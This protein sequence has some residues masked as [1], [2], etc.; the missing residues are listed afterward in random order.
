MPRKIILLLLIV[1]CCITL[2][3]NRVNSKDAS[4]AVNNE[5]KNILI[6]N[7]YHQGFTWTGEETQGI[8]NSLLESGN[9]ISI[10]VEYMDWKNHPSQENL[11]YLYDYYKYKYQTTKIDIIIATDDAALEFALNNRKDLFKDA[12]VVFCGINQAGIKTITEGADRVTGVTEVVDPTATIQLALQVNPD[13]KNVYLL[14][15]NTES[16]LSTGNLA[17]KQI[18]DIAPQ[19]NIISCNRLAF[20]D[21]LDTVHKLKRDSIVL[22]TTYYRDANNNIFEMDYVNRS[23]SEASTV[24]VYHLYDFGLNKGI[25]GGALLSGQLQGE[26]AADLALR[27]LS[28]EDPSDIP[29][30]TE[31]SYRVVFDYLQLTRF[32]IDP[33]VLPKD[34]RIINKP[35]SFFE[36]YQTLVIS[37]ISAFAVLIAFLLI[38][39]AYLRKIARMK[40]NLSESNEELTQLY[41]ELAASDEEMRQQYDEMLLI[42]EKIRLGEDKLTYLAYHDSLTGLLN[43]LSLYDRARHVFTPEN[44]KAALLFIDIDNFKN[45]NDAMG[46]AFG[47]QLIIKVSERLSS[48]SDDNR[49]LYRLSGDEFIMMLEKYHSMEEVENA[50][51]EIMAKFSDEFNVLESTLNISLSI[52]IA[53]YPEHGK[54]LEQL[55][56]YSDIA[57]YRAKEAGRKNYILY[58]NFMNEVFTERMS[59]EKHL[60]NALDN[61]EFEVYYQPQLDLKSNQITG[62]EALLRW[63]SPELGEV[64]PVKFIEVAED[65]R[66]ILP[67]GTWVIKNAC[68]FLKKLKDMGLEN[69]T[70][71]VNISILQ[72]LQPDFCDI[73]E[74]SLKECQLSPKSLELEITESI[75]ME[76]FE[77]IR[78]GLKRLHARDIRI[79]LDDFGKGYSS[80]NYLRQL[81]ITT[82]K[83]DKSFIDHICSKNTSNLTQH[84]ITIGKSMGM[85]VIAEGVEKQEQL[86]YLMEHDCDKIQGFLFS[87]PLPEN[88]I[89][90]LFKK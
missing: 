61:N 73:V 24:P 62:F 25:I 39:L 35:F 20:T 22:I 51:R 63:H 90:K 56:R 36:T 2:P 70:A 5:I 81:P 10:Q 85:C 15:D 37:V 12:P 31:G 17:I 16:G 88:E 32:H 19:L 77:S 82:L 76:S 83:V 23:I 21:L 44:G 41:E 34:A 54:D 84:I 28:G 8:I 78:P 9:N 71:S 3:Y 66:Y 64:S 33:D 27:I 67:I 68:R 89:I 14:Y 52:G 38:L 18:K 59:I 4:A 45:V 60:Q 86:E 58:D 74:S 1:L 6:I 13:L 48:I 55:L 46:H 75:L 72:L 80:L 26:Y 69:L 53:L 30:I 47:D 65:T 29:V 57:M 49:S 50:A 43:K 40:K 87:K 11:E 42:N 79:A 7:S